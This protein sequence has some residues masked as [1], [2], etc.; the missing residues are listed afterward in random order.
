MA[1]Q[2][3]TLFF[4]SCTMARLILMD[5][6]TYYLIR[7]WR[8]TMMNAASVRRRVGDASTGKSKPSAPFYLFGPFSSNW[9]VER[10]V[11]CG[12]SFIQDGR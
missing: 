6:R 10:V 8:I 11:L 9:L 4:H 1:F 12:T 7:M 5:K 3:D 2:A